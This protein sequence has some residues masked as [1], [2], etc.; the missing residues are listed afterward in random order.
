MT[1][2]PAAAASAALTCVC[3]IAAAAAA[4]RGGPGRRAALRTACTG[5]AGACVLAWWFAGGPAVGGQPRGL[6]GPVRVLG[7]DLGQASL[8]AAVASLAISQVLLV[9]AL[10]TAWRAADGGTPPGA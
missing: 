3:L 10:R 6:P 4:R 5:A 7:G 9:S 2:W 1:L 8:V